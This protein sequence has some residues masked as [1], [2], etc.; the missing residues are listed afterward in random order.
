MAK[1]ETTYKKITG[2]DKTYSEATPVTNEE[3]EDAIK[4]KST[5]AKKKIE[6]GDIN[7]LIPKKNLVK[8]I[9]KEIRKSTEDKKIEA[10]PVNFE[11][12]DGADVSKETKDTLNKIGTGEY[13]VP[14]SLVK[15][16]AMNLD[17]GKNLREMNE[18]HVTPDNISEKRVTKRPNKRHI[19]ELRRRD[20]YFNKTCAACGER[21]L[22]KNMDGGK[23][24]EC[25]TCR[26]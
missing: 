19:I 24:E 12:K 6:I 26:K 5:E 23:A 16:Q 4:D 21:K 22:L 9:G 3:L 1:T 25:D 8:D 13:K 2:D 11:V 20:R 10:L 18:K 15:D 17:Y 14:E 7:I